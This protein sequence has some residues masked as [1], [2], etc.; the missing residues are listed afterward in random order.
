LATILLTDPEQRAGLAAARSL[1]RHGWRVITVG[2]ARGLAGH[3]RAVSQHYTV[4]AADVRSPERYRECVQH[5]VTREHAEVVIPISDS[6]S[7]ALLGFDALLG[8]RIAGP[9]VEAYV[10]ASD[11]AGL[12]QTAAALGLRVPRQY[13]LPHR[14]A[15]IDTREEIRGAVVLKP[16]SSVVTVA[17]RSVSV[18]VQYV[19]DVNALEHALGT[20]PPEAYPLLVQERTVG[21]GI[22]VFLLRTDG[23][24]HLQ[25]AHRRLREKPPAGGVST[26]RESIIPPAALVQLCETLLDALQYS[27]PAM[28]EFKQDAGTGEYVLM[29]INARFWGSLQLAIDAGIDFPAVLAELTLHGTVGASPSPKIGVR[30]AWEL[31]ELDHAL[32][33]IRHSREKLHAPDSMAIGW[34]AAIRALLDRRLSDHA[35]VFRWS[36]PLPFMAEAMRWIRRA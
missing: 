14:G 5:I 21:D 26:Y 29:E 15:T 11:K 33:L 4:S 35:E 31:G 6:A 36:D 28:I 12:L 24:T 20:Y 18:G 17:G 34:K 30:T 9:S 32:A 8:A 2:A 16:T 1:D 25:F 23:T 19:S 7:R 22:G 10:R 13:V 27:G 3:S